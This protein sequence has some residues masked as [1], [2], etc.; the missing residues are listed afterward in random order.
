MLDEDAPAEVLH[1]LDCGSYRG[2][3]VSVST[4][5][6]RTQ[7]EGP[8]KGAPSPQCENEPTHAC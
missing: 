6:R 5:E 4:Y 3:R 2:K 1:A 8:R 7:R